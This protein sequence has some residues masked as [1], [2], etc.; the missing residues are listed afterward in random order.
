M[1]IFVLIG[2]GATEEKFFF[3]KKSPQPS[4]IQ[5]LNSIPCQCDKTPEMT[6]NDEGENFKDTA[7]EEIVKEILKDVI[8]KVIKSSTNSSS[9]IDEQVSNE[10]SNTTAAV[11]ID[12]TEP[13]I[14]VSPRRTVEI[15]ISDAQ[16]NSGTV[17]DSSCSRQRRKKSSKT[18]SVEEENSA[19][20]S[21]P[22][23]GK[24]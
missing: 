8:E 19:S 21:N 2:A 10:S 5:R 24:Y 13:E 9:S 6:N 23:R 7:G 17:G 11:E 1:A 14:K 18:K 16:P 3:E 15:D 22:S 4:R 12:C 20:T